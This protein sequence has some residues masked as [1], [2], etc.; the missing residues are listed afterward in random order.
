MQVLVAFDGSPGAVAALEVA[1]RLVRPTDGRVVALRVLNP[2]VDATDIVAPTAAEAVRRAEVRE[3]E[4]LD[5]VVESIGG[6]EDVELELVVEALA[7]GEDVPEHL[8]RAARER[9][10]DLVA[11]ASQRA[12]GLKGLLLG[13]VTQHVLRLSERP[14]LVVRPATES[15]PR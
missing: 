13:S 10:T 8:V 6:L 12:A 15:A 2:L 11:I 5:A 3:R 14:V 9:E 7:H 4:R 1:A